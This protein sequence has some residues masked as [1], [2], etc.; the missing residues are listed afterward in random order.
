MVEATPIISQRL[1]FSMSRAVIVLA[2]QQAEKTIKHG[3]AAKGRKPGGMRRREIVALAREYLGKH[4]ELFEQT[5]PVVE[6]W[7]VEGSSASALA[8]E[9][10][11]QV[12]FS[13]EVPG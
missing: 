1:R 6:R 3:L 2:Q 5:K 11:S 8:F 10:N 9:R 12:M 7:R 13:T 4:Q